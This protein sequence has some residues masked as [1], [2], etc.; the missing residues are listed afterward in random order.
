[1]RGEA[2]KRAACVLSGH[3]AVYGDSMSVAALF[4]HTS[5]DRVLWGSTV[6]REFED[7]G[8]LATGTKLRT[9]SRTGCIN[10]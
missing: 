10:S 7:G 3:L 8:I 6:Q 1:M 2:K 4:V 9:W 5:T